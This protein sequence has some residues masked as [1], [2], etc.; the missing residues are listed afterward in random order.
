MKIDIATMN[1]DAA[2]AKSK[3]KLDNL[4]EEGSRIDFFFHFSYYVSET[5]SEMRYPTSF[6]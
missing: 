2:N 5:L 4:S 3:N 6:I 1:N